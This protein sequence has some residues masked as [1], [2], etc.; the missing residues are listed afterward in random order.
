M[1]PIER[2]GLVALLFLIVTVVAVVLW[3]KKSDKD[4]TKTPPNPATIVTPSGTTTGPELGGGAVAPSTEVVATPGNGAASGL[5][6]GNEVAAP[7]QPITPSGVQQPVA[8]PVGSGSNVGPSTGPSDAFGGGVVQRPAAAGT[9]TVKK[10]DTLSGIAK[11]QLGSANRYG[12]IAAL[13]P[14]LDPKRMKVGQTLKLPGGASASAGTQAASAPKVAKATPASANGV[15]Y[16]VRR[17]ESLWAIAQSQLGDGD[18]YT[19][20]AA[21][22]PKLDPNRLVVGMKLRLPMTRSQ[23]PR[24]ATNRTAVA[25]NAQRKG[26]VL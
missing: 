19:E 8:T 6:G 20:I 17:G 26:G 12:E 5:G 22:N 14:G 9:Y 4:K 1:Q 16:T 3:D 10:G 21:L 25:A 7:Q 24:A 23:A 18:R 13:N 2:Y 15:E 11:S